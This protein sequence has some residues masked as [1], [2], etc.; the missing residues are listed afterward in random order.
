MKWFSRL[1]PRD[2]RSQIDPTTGWHQVRSK[3]NNNTLYTYLP[4][5]EL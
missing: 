2:K 5:Y 3:R 1:A 4:T